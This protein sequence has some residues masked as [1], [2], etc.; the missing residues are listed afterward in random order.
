M[1]VT[2]ILALRKEG[3]TESSRAPARRISQSHSPYR[4]RSGKESPRESRTFPEVL[5]TRRRR[6]P[7]PDRRH[8]GLVGAQTPGASP[9]PGGK[10]VRRLR[11]LHVH[12]GRPPGHR[13]RLGHHLPHLRRPLPP[14][15]QHRPASRSG[16]TSR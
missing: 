4:H 9:G 13:G 14:V 5:G 8:S 2:F 7:R 6:G 16:R 12:P 15:G 11:Q 10:V 1:T 3:R